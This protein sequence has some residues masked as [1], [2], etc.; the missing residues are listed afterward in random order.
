[1]IFS[2]R[3]RHSECSGVPWAP[4]CGIEAGVGPI[5]PAAPNRK[6]NLRGSSVVSGTSK[7]GELKLT[8]VARA[9]LEELLTDYRDFLRTRNMH[10]WDKDNKEKASA[11]ITDFTEWMFRYK[12][13]LTALQIF[14]NQPFRRRELT[15]RMI[16]ELLEKLMTDKPSLSPMNVWRAYE[17]LENTSGKP[18]KDLT[19]LVS[20][21]RRV[22]GID[23]TLT[24]YDKTIDK[25][26][27]EWMFRK[28]AG[29]HNR[30]TPEQMNWLY[31]IKD[32]VTSSERKG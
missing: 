11:L 32:Y 3:K 8:G 14:Y 15:F 7:E 6:P 30:F 20:L 23:E 28:N 18:L 26:F 5:G 27:K 4:G 17:T 22:Y 10:L 1:M 9:S 12:D 19:A 29:Q 31:M 21:I 25:N 24:S 16:Q 2:R 13:E